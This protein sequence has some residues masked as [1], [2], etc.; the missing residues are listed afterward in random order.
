ML[1]RQL[2]R[3]YFDS[4]HTQ[5]LMNEFVYEYN[6]TNVGDMQYTMVVR[7]PNANTEIGR[8]EVYLSQYWSDV[9]KHF[10]FNILLPYLSFNIDRHLR[11]STGINGHHGI[12][13]LVYPFDNNWKDIGIS[14]TG[15]NL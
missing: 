12:V 1:N 7:S 10:I 8:Q 3:C 5:Q 11:A 2:Y 13:L 6:S 4:M 15:I 9:C 14:C